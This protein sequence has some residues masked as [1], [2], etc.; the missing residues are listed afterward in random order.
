[1]VKVA[2]RPAENP[3]SDLYRCIPSVI[4]SWQG[5]ATLLTLPHILT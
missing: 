5:L 4:L 2:T 3:V 1:M